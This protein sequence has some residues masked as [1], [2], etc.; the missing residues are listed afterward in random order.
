MGDTSTRGEDIMTKQH[1]WA[2]WPRW[3]AGGGRIGRRP[4]RHRL[5]PAVLALED[6]RL[7]AAFTVNSPG[8]ADTGSGNAGTLLYCITQADSNGQ[9][10]TILFDSQVFGS[11][12]TIALGGAALELS[13]Q[14]GT[15]SITGPAAGVTIDAGGKSRVFAIDR[16][17]TASLSG[18]T[19]TGGSDQRGG[20]GVYSDGALTLTG[21]TISGNSAGF[22]GGLENDATATLQDCTISGN[23]ATFSGGG[24]ENDATATLQDCTIS[25]NSAGNAGG[26]YATGS[27]TLTDCTV[28]GNDAD[29]GAGGLSADRS[30]SVT[31]TGCTISG[32][33][34]GVG[35]GGGILSSVPVTL[36]G[37]TI[38][39][40]SASRGGGLEIEATVT[41]QDCTISGNSA[42]QA[43]GLEGYFATATLQ[44]CTISGNS[45]T[46]RGGIAVGYVNATS[47]TGTI[48]AGN[49]GGDIA[50]SVAGS[51]NLI[52]TGGSGGLTNGVDGNL[53]GV[54]D[55]LLAPL[56]PYGG[57]T[58]TIALLP[59]SPAIGAGTAISGITTDQ[60]GV[61]RPTDHPDV[62][63]FQ[64]RGF[65]ISVVSGDAQHTPVGQAFARPLIARVASPSGDPVAGG[66]V[67]FTPPASG[68]SAELGRPPAA[69]AFS[70]TI[71]R[72]GRAQA[73]ATANDVP[74]SYSVFA[75]AAGAAGA[76]GFTLRNTAIPTAFSGLAGPTIVYGTATTALGGTI[77]AGSTA[78]PGS[79]AITL[80]G[81]TQDAAI[82]ADGTFSS[83]FDTATLGVAGSPYTI[84]Y[85]YAA[86]DGYAAATDTSHALTVTRAT[87]TVAVS[88]A[89]GLAD[90][91]PFPATATVTGVSG[92][93]APSLE[94]V[95]V[96][97]VPE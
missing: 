18:L 38:S 80:D 70:A 32:N 74:G 73:A 60:R 1:G 68:A 51:N 82:A 46:A 17:V 35:D 53:V 4:D 43:G 34:A 41:L 27:L 85:A 63:A 90:G 56:G 52:G 69:G 2:R 78:P 72:A 24:L 30:G 15:Q 81:V 25:G 37:C 10:N 47:L 49:R 86:Q 40:N 95:P 97:V 21:C 14:G 93:A 48:V 36:T 26:V 7:L 45:A 33:S 11:H 5:R 83:A 20:G 89:G 13:D 29:D 39:G 91:R 76:V 23:S 31:L 59:G 61:A 88:D 84:T 65:T 96:A 67:T 92:A 54:A 50:G 79:V 44:D 77:L 8:A 75:S 16:G 9:A 19:I 64:D 57:P 58:E 62:G 42:F 28:S 66:V 71:S 3:A 94:G 55:P 87:P 12:R 22:G 6:R